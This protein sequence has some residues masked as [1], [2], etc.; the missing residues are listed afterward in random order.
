V[1]KTQRRRSGLQH[2]RVRKIHRIGD[3]RKHQVTLTLYRIII[4]IRLPKEE[5]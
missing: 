5:M 4:I 1:A 2:W 3:P